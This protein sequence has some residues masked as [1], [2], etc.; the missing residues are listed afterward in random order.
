MTDSQPKRP[1]PIRRLYEWVLG[2][3]DTPY[4]VLAMVLVSFG[5]SSCF[6]LPPDPLLMALV[7]GNRKKAWKFA[8]YCTVASVAG[9]ALGY[10]I[11]SSFW[12]AAESVFIP[13]LFKCHHFL[14]VGNRYADNAFLAVF[15]AAFTPIPFKVFTI[16]AGVYSD[17]VDFGTLIGASVVGR[18]ARF[19]LVAGLLFFFGPPMRRF[20]EKHLEWLTLTFTVLLVGG[21]VIIKGA[22]PH[23]SRDGLCAQ[24]KVLSK[25]H[26]ACV[27]SDENEVDRPSLRAPSASSKVPPGTTLPET[28]KVAPTPKPTEK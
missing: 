23:T 22:G 1:N 12:H 14:E 8:A 26:C 13:T 17:L 10:V 7:L 15:T 21:I 4:G 25:T 5:D 16:S 9:A 6:P 20:I 24:G 18:G 11:G 28:P 19:F 2:W 3:A 27:S